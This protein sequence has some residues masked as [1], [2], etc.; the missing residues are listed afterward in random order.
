MENRILAFFFCIITGSV[1]ASE[2]YVNCNASAAGDGSKTAPF[3]T[4]QQAADC[5]NP[6]DTVIIMPGVYFESVKLKRFG[7][8]GKPITFRTDKIKRRR[9]ILSG[10]D[11]DIRNKKKQWTLFDTERQI[12]SIPYDAME[13]SRVLYDEV[14][15]YPYRSLDALKTLEAIP[16]IP[17]PRHGFVQ[18]NGKLF[19][20]L[21][22]DGKYG[23]VNPNHHVIA[24]APS[25]RNGLNE[26]N[27]RAYNFGLLGGE[28][29]DLHVVLDGLTFETPGIAAVYVDGNHAVIRNALFLGCWKGGVVG[30]ARER[31]S[32]N[33]TLEFSEFHS[34]PIYQDAQELTVE[35]K[36]GKRHIDPQKKRLH[37][38]VHKSRRLNGA[39]TPYEYGIVSGIGKSWTIR[40]CY[41]HD[42]FEAIAN[43]DGD[44]MIF[45]ENRCERLIDNGV[46]LEN[47]GRH[48]HIRR[49]YFID[50]FQAISM[51]PLC[52]HPW[53][54][55]N[56]VYQNI[57]YRTPED[58][59]WRGSAFKIG[60]QRRMW[61]SSKYP[62]LKGDSWKHQSIPGLLIFN[63]T[64][65]EPN[66]VVF[67]DLERYQKIDNISFYNNL[68]V[69]PLLGW[70][71]RKTKETGG[72]FYHFSY[73][74]NRL[75]I[76]RQKVESMPSSVCNQLY[77]PEQ[78]LPGW[79]K[80]QIIPE[81]FEPAVPF[82]NAPRQ[83]RYVGALQSPDDSFAAN[84]GVQ[85]ARE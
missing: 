11:P 45:E 74:G 10:A 41:I 42:A 56:Y 33:V 38:W 69:S 72:G 34:F 73:A 79:E 29:Q 18:E 32:S 84:V 65:I 14:D 35:V 36:D 59:V 6:G 53:P 49:N 60:I 31:S 12:Y 28:G 63:N 83:F 66:D 57:F 17:G 75:A 23:S 22:Q 77:S 4:I 47:H 39:I 40:N 62:Y 13:P 24:V 80:N 3:A 19:I 7:Q 1:F 20:R 25:S 37:W 70:G 21:R 78:V 43:S 54:G 9:V 51:Q 85:E 68:V 46:E 50:I 8:P 76:T 27:T 67:A 58:R 2:L 16:G 82:E 81:K 30:K 71:S 55:P 48:C 44:H 5:V 64:I 26:K 61:N 15:L 52:G